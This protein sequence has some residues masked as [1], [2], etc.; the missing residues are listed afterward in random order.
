MKREKSAVHH[1]SAQQIKIG[2]GTKA[3]RE[4]IAPRRF[5][6]TGEG[7]VNLRKRAKDVFEGGKKKWKSGSA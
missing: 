3:L 5:Y 1:S 7:M 2:C 4:L 6:A